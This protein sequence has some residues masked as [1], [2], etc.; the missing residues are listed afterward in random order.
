V[1]AIV[2][3]LVVAGVVVV[4]MA[5]NAP[6]PEQQFANALNSVEG[7]AS[8]GTR[9][10]TPRQA[11]FTPVP[12]SLA[13]SAQQRIEL[14]CDVAGSTVTFFSFRSAAAF[15]GSL[16]AARSLANSH[17]CTYGQRYLIVDDGLWYAEERSWLLQICKEL[18]ARRLGTTASWQRVLTD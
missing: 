11:S 8:I 15:R 5:L 16:A 4:V 17:A 2:V 14:S 10:L 7:C 12:L 6:S 18:H 3:F 1:A 9:N 13:E